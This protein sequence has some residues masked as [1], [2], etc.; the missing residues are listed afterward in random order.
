MRPWC[1]QKIFS[2]VQPVRVQLNSLISRSSFSH[3]Y[4]VGLIEVVRRNQRPINS[5]TSVLI[6]EYL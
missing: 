2:K 4:H 6:V 5:K 1:L 3:R